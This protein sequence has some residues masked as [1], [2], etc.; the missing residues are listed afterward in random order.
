MPKFKNIYI[1]EQCGFQSPKWVGKCPDCG[2]WNSFIE[3]V[4]EK[5]SSKTTVEGKALSPTPL[6]HEEHV[7]TR[8]DT[9]I[10][11]LNRVLGGGLV[12]GSLVLLSG[13]PGIGKSTLTL[14]ICNHIA[15]QK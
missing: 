9:K 15:E 2:A 13:E 5:I 11:E 8:L 7:E 10:E 4:I 6:V 3:D 1:C 12:K 14:Q